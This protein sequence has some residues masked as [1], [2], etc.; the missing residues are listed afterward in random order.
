M[1]AITIET[2]ARTH[3]QMT[4]MPQAGNPGG[5]GVASNKERTGLGVAFD[6]NGDKLSVVLTQIPLNS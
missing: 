4:A 3:T 6:K 2:A 1:I 5:A